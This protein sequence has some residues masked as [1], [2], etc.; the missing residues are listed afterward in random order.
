MCY[1]LH[2]PKATHQRHHKWQYFFFFID[3][4][5]H[6]IT[7]EVIADF[8]KRCLRQQED[9]D[10][11]HDNTDRSQHTRFSPLLILSY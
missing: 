5:T 6:K 1:M 10:S 7:H 4:Q 3:G 11:G 9:E 8:F 2:V